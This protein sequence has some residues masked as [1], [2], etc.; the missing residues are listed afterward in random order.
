[1]SIKALLLGS[2]GAV[3][4]SSDIQRRAYNQALAEAGSSWGWDPATYRA[5]LTEPGGMA[6]LARLS[7]ADGGSLTPAQIRSI[8]ARK[9]EIACTEVA[10][11]IALRPGIAPLIQE[12]L[13]AGIALGFVTS[14]YRANIDAIATGAGE[15]LP[16]EQFAIVV[17]TD[18]VANGKPAPDVYEFALQQLDCAAVDAVAIEDSASS[19]AAAKAAGIYTVCTPG[20]FTAEQDASAADRILDSLEGFTLADLRPG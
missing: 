6:R 17:T 4:E 8:H 12:A 11:G 13:H 5:L 18:D 1:M 14:T 19:V 3:A 2:I 20:E 10:A 16:L 15:A 7:D 9:T